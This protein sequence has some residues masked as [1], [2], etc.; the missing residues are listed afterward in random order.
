MRQKSLLSKL[1]LLLAVLFVGVGSAWAAE[2]ITDYTQI[3][4]GKT[5][6]I[7][8]TVSNTDYYF[9]ALGTYASTSGI[10]GTSKTD[11]SE[12]VELVFEGSGDQWTVKFGS[13]KY[14]SLKS[15]K[16][17]G[18]VTV[19]NDAATWTLSN[20][21]SLIKMTINGYC[22]QK[23]SSSS[24][25]FGSYQDTQTNVWLEEAYSEDNI[26]KLSKSAFSHMIKIKNLDLGP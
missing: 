11:K 8:A 21:N 17:N 14:L 7:G 20:S 23:N 5:Y 26:G 24:L 25:N 9:Y 18:K 4:S 16:D 2:K 12:A 15:S 22:L 10:A 3:V 6:Y 13:G 1:M 19:L